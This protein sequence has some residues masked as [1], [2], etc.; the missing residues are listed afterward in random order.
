MGNAGKK[1]KKMEPQN[2][3]QGEIEQDFINFGYEHGFKS[4]LKQAVK[5]IDKMY[6]GSPKREGYVAW[7][8][9]HIN[10]LKSKIKGIGK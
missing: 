2:K 8:K 4:A 6:N 9:E 3:T 7:G 5:M 10:E 1:E